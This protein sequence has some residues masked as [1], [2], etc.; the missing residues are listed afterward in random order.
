MLNMEQNPGVDL[1]LQQGCMRCPFGG[2]LQ[3]KVHNWPEELNLL[4]SILLESALTEEIKWG[5]PCYTFDNKNILIL[6]AFKE[7]CSLS[8]FKGVLLHDPEN[9]LD[10]PGE[11]TQS[12]RLI[13][14]TSTDQIVKSQTQIEQFI[15][16]AID[17]EISG[18]QVEFPQKHN[19]EYPD[20]FVRK[21][22][23]DPFLKA[24]FESLTPG[25]KRGYILHFSQPKQSK[26]RESRIEKCVEKILSGKGFFN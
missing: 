17:N 9:L 2:T 6:S 26:T 3:C 22:E 1:Y 25:R 10:K 15:Q 23:E 14:F 11:N 19:L 7:Y 5:V 20:E 13:K 24:A 18:K 21:L 4:R 12:A 8:F 16:E